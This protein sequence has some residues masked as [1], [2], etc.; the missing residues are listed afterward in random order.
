MQPA[1]LL[2]LFNR[3]GSSRTCG[4][5]QIREGILSYGTGGLCARRIRQDQVQSCELKRMNERGTFRIICLVYGSK[6][7][8]LRG[9]GAALVSP[10]NGATA[11]C[12]KARSCRLIWMHSAEVDALFRKKSFG[13]KPRTC[14]V[15]KRVFRQMSTCGSDFCPEGAAYNSPGSEKRH[16]GVVTPTRTGSYPVGVA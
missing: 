11:T 16:P 3:P 12:A 1:A 6:V 8:A 9:R 2:C 10:C 13:H 15:Q 7:D 14:R 4:L 5:S